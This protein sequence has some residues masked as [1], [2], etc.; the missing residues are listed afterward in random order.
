[1]MFSTAA[2]ATPLVTNG[3]FETGDFSGWTANAGNTISVN[4]FYG[5][6]DG[7]YSAQ[8]DYLKNSGPGIDYLQQTITT[9][10]GTTYQ[11]DFDFEGAPRGT[12][13]SMLVSA[14]D[15]VNTLASLTVSDMPNGNVLPSHFSHFSLTFIANSASTTISFLDTSPNTFEAN[16]IFD[17]V[18]VVEASASTA[19]PE[20]GSLALLS[21]S[22]IGLGISGR[23]RT[24]K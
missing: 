23:R 7:V 22:L 24:Q 20:P 1:M 3:S 9:A 12:L 19:V 18:V 6:T 21:L 14:F 13:Q 17:N 11:L 15:G 5:A 10:A 4:T 2:Q 8:L 16:A